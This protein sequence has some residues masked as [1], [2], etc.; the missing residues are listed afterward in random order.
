ML[1]KNIVSKKLELQNCSGL[2][3]ILISGKSGVGKTT[4]AR[5]I[6]NDY[7]ENIIELYPS[8]IFVDGDLNKVFDDVYSACICNPKVFIFDEFQMYPLRTQCSLLR[9]LDNIPSYVLVILCSSSLSK[10]LDTIKSRINKHIDLNVPSRDEL[11]DLL[12]EN[13]IQSGVD[14]DLSGFDF[15]IDRC[16]G[17]IRSLLNEFTLV[18]EQL[19]KITLFS[20]REVL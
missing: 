11:I 9:L 4:L 10:V 1:L 5:L 15:L 2:N 8:D 12:K 3:S 13:S 7:C 17:N 19:G 16:N 6:A 18:K 20:V 14:Y